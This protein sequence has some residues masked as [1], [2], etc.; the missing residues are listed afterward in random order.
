M[1]LERIGVRLMAEGA[2][3]Y[4]NALSEAKRATQMFANEVTQAKNMLSGASSVN[5]RYQTTMQALSKQIG[6]TAEETRIYRNRQSELKTTLPKLERYHAKLTTRYNQEKTANAQLTE[7]YTTANNKYKE[8]QAETK[9]LWDRKEELRNKSNELRETQEKLTAEIGKGSKGQDDLQKELKET[10]ADLEE[11]EKQVEKARDAWRKAKDTRNELHEASKKANK[12]AR[13]S[14]ESFKQTAKEYQSSEK[15][16]N[17]YKQELDGLPLK[18]SNSETATAKLNK[19]LE[20]TTISYL[21]AG[22]TWSNAAATL[23]KFGSRMQ[24]MGQTTKRIGSS[25]T[26]NVTAPIVTLG[27]AAA[28]VG[29]KFEH[30]MSKVGAVSEASAGQ[31]RQMAEQAKYLGQT[32]AFSATEVAEGMELVGQAGFEANQVMSMMPGIIN[33][34]TVSGNDMALASETMAVALNSFNLE[35]TEA[36]HVADVFAKAAV[37]TNAEVADMAEAFKYAAP[38]ASQLGISIEETAAA[39]GVL[40]DRGL[41]GSMAGTSF[42]TMLTKMTHQTAEGKRTMDELGISFTDAEGRLRPL[43]DIIDNMNSAMEGLTDAQKQSALQTMF[44]IRGARAANIMMSEGSEALRGLTSDLENSDG[45]AQKLADTFRDNLAGT[46]KEMRGAL[47]TAGIDITE[48]L[49]PMLESA[50][51]AVTKIARSF[52]S[53]SKEQQQSIVKWFA[54]AA[55]LGPA[56]KVL[57]SV[58]EGIGTVGKALSTATS[59]VG[60]AR[61]AYHLLTGQFGKV[62]ASGG[63]LGSAME[64]LTGTTSGTI[65]PVQSAAAAFLGLGGEGASTAAIMTKLSGVL[66]TAGPIVLGVAG[67]AAAGYGAWK[68]YESTVGKTKEQVRR[69]GYE[70]SDSMASSVDATQKGADNL[71]RAFDSIATKGAQASDDVSQAF[72]RMSQESISEVNEA[73]NGMTEA[74]NKMPPAVQETLADVQKRMTQGGEGITRQIEETN[75]KAQAIIKRAQDENR[76]LN[77][78]EQNELQEHYDTISKL[79]LKA[80][81]KDQEEMKVARRTNA[82]DMR[83]WSKKQLKERQKYLKQSV[84]DQKKAYEENKKQLDEWLAH[85][86]MTNQEYNRSLSELNQEHK[87]SLEELAADWIELGKAQGKSA[88][89]IRKTLEQLGLDYQA[90]LQVLEDRTNENKNFM[91]IVSSEMSE[92]AQSAGDAWNRLVQELNIDELSAKTQKVLQDFAATEDGW[93]QL[94][95]IAKEAD[96]NDNTRLFIAQALKAHDRWGE[97]D[98]ETKL[99]IITTQGGEELIAAAKNLG[100]W[101]EMEPEEKLALASVNIDEFALEALTAKGTWDNVELLEKLAKIDT[102]DSAQLQELF[103]EIEDYNGLKLELKDGK[104]TVSENSIPEAQEALDNWNGTKA[105]DKQLVAEY[106]SEEDVLNALAQAGAWDNTEFREKVMNINADSAEE[107]RQEFARLVKDYFGIE[108]EEKEGRFTVKTE[109]VDEAEQKIAGYDEEANRAAQE[110]HAKFMAEIGDLSYSASWV[111]AWQSQVEAASGDSTGTF[112]GEA[113]TETVNVMDWLDS[114]IPGAKDFFSNFWGKATTPTE[115]VEGWNETTSLSKVA[116]ASEFQASTNAGENAPFVKEWNDYLYATPEEKSS[117]FQSWTNTAENNPLIEEW[118]RYVNASPEERQSMLETATNAGEHN[119][120]AKLWAEIVTTVPEEKLSE[121]L[122]A[123]NAGDHQQAAE[124]W[125]QV[126]DETLDEKNSTMFTSAPTA[127]GD[128]K[129]VDDWTRAQSG[130]FDTSTTASTATPNIGGNTGLVDDWTRSQKATIN[131]STRAT[132]AAPGIDG[133]TNQINRWTDAQRDTR[134][135]NT[136][137]TTST[138]ASS[139][140][141]Q[142][143][144]WTSAVRSAPRSITSVFTTIKRTITEFFSR[145]RQTGD[146]YLPTDSMVHI[147]EGGRKEPYLTPSGY[148]G[149]SGYDEYIPLPKGTRIWPNRQAF[150]QSA[151]FNKSLRQYL[152]QIPKFAKGG[153]IKN[154][155]DGYTG[156]V[157]EAGPEIFRVAQGNV[158]ITPLR[159]GRRTKEL[160]LGNDSSKT[161]SLLTQLVEQNAQLLRVLTGLGGVVED[162]F[163]KQSSHSEESIYQYVDSQF[164]RKSARSVMNMRGV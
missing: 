82:N 4:R 56:I 117:M 35:A 90:G 7:T 68:I 18:I 62:A 19:E 79:R 122:A 54:Y 104:I 8:A 101:N 58:Q 3:Q 78:T 124:M 6:A 151:K 88:D 10:T 145:D 60:G 107:A 146:L 147:G 91:A 115:E 152:S 49:T 160:E 59:V 148:F 53:L 34:A 96:I 70:V 36:S 136:R 9:R 143:R 12:T 86:K 38:T 93:N 163:A 26:R 42:N 95:F 2:E 66:S 17:A 72:A 135:T 133:R 114:V 76:A 39:I 164:Q 119:P 113:E 87:K 64:K 63:K 43:P 50:A 109:G 158:T 32:T 162:G 100:I 73:T 45:A 21:K 25:L 125:K 116:I 92:Q 33:M 98:F 44:G 157:G 120:M 37:A 69:F 24:R 155:Y 153:R 47:E 150:R 15:A 85:G 13:E 132:T 137:A 75:K 129:K 52:S 48:A 74:F 110:K 1:A 22:G 144:D 106:T 141:W 30:Q 130:T 40:S 123:T 131:S 41:K 65:G 140:T 46:L 16:L 159:S 142:V 51:R 134:S 55:A 161:D 80:V 89:D 156:L 149:V 84:N 128:T 20:Q 154:P 105:T 102:S 108:L 111:Q 127:V 118:Q 139:N 81:A 11:N 83:T 29:I 138:N 112:H 57:G 31:L 61:T 121:L 28:T 27:T 14:N 71:A 23:D 103:G 99:A 67:A 97:L 5:S 126:V 77:R 94:E